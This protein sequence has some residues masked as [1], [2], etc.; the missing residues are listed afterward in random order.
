MAFIRSVLRHHFICL[1]LCSK[2]RGTQREVPD[3]RR[4]ITLWVAIL[5]VK[6][7]PT[8]GGKDKMKPCSP[9]RISCLLLCFKTTK[10]SDFMNTFKKNYIMNKEVNG[11]SFAEKVGQ[12]P[13][14]KITKRLFE[15]QLF[16]ALLLFF[17]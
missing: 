14:E 7:I 9:R 15:A 1:F 5:L 16:S 17:Y 12:S 13:I 10:R 6:I 8:S 11:F 4:E 2:M 3:F